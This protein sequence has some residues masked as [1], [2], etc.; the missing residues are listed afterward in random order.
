MARAL[1][2]RHHWEDHTGLIGDALETRGFEVDLRMMNADNP[3][4]SLDGYDLMVILG[5][6][7]AV[8]DKEVEASWFGR[9]LALIADAERRDLP[10]FGI[11]FGAQA[12]CLYHGG[13]VERSPE[14]EIGWYDVQA[15][16]NADIAIG[17]W[18]EFHFDRCILPDKAE[19]WATSPHAVQAFRVGRHLGVQFHPEIDHVQLRDWLAG[20]DDEAR[21]FGVDVDALIER[22]AHETPAARERAGELIDIFLAHCVG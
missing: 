2:L 10:I 15:E 21:E 18:F 5:S 12:L 3:S 17:P 13:T 14:P 7:S 9:E 4:P 19:L 11:C 8:Y 16:N 6:K 1:V 20:G 22:T